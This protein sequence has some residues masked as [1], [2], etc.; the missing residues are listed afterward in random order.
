MLEKRFSAVPPQL[1]AANGATNG[2][3][4]I[5]DSSLFKVKQVVIVASNT[6]PNLELEVKNVLSSTQIVV[7]PR[8]GNI[9]ATTDISSYLTVDGA[10]VFANEQKRPTIAGDEITRSTY[11]EEP[12]VANRTILVDQ[13]GNK[14]TE[15][16]PLPTSAVVN[17]GD[18]TIG[19]VS[20]GEPNTA[21][22]AWPV[23]ISGGVDAVGISTVDT[24]KA[25]KVDV[26]RS[27][28][29]AKT[30][31]FTYTPSGDVETIETTIGNKKR[32]EQFTYNGQGDLITLAVT[33]EDV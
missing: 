18:I 3:A 17:L 31:S 12:T 6:Q 4:V 2:V 9:F 30:T 20:Q 1:F 14:I 11:E 27:E 25:L 10:N 8:T 19:A 5:S 23:K 22:N 26:V 13:F 28:F 21:D 29:V 24:A 32:V 16:N 7:G 33:I 15:D